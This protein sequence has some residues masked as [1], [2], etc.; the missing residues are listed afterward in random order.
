M[1]TND[2]SKLELPSDLQ[3]I[4]A[5]SARREITESGEILVRG[6]PVAPAKVI[7]ILQP[8]LTSDRTDRIISVVQSRTKTVIPVVEGAANTGNVGAVM[9]TAEGLGFDEFH[10][11][12]TDQKYKR[13]GRSSRG[14]AK[15]LDVRTWKAVPECVHHLRR[16]GYRIL[17]TTVAP[18][19][20]RLDEV[21]FTRKTALILG[22][23]AEGVSEAVLSMAD[24]AVRADLTGFVES[25][26]ISVAAAIVLH[27]AYRQRVN[28][29]GSN[30]DLKS[31]EARLLTA[32]YYLRAVQNGDRIVT[33]ELRRSG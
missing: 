13:S 19:S 4:I 9:R 29:L 32:E 31:Q 11:I 24:G 17:A 16:R 26:N 25:Y 10:V 1:S 7:E 8:Y 15:W 27:H 18:G 20:S 3:P 28:R 30:G 14:A 5:K 23:E 2:V 21:D 22:N 12:A 33:E 6:L